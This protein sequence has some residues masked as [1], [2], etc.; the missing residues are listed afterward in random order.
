[1]NCPH[2][3]GGEPATLKCRARVRRIVPTRVG[4]NRLWRMCGTFPS[5]IV[6]TRVG[7][8]RQNGVR[9]TYGRVIVPT[10]VGVNR[11]RFGPG[12]APTDCPHA[13]GGEPASRKA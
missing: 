9:E 1:M 5:Y 8:N 12:S 3:R 7:V 11:K 10:R 6:P 2:T 4:V 13:R